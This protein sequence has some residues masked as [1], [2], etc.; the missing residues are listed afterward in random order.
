LHWQSKAN[1]DFWHLEADGPLIIPPESAY[2]FV[3]TGKSQEISIDAKT[4]S[5]I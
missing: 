5:N 3:E 1:G 4:V 2:V